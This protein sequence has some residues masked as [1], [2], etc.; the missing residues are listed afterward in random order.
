MQAK[1]DAAQPILLP[2]HHNQFRGGYT[3]NKVVNFRVMTLFFVK[4]R[5][6]VVWVTHKIS[7]KLIEKQLYC[8]MN[9][10]DFWQKTFL[11]YKWL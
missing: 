10:T 1:V 11:C 8:S 9:P 7:R 6:F 3:L 4:Y 5:A 2:F